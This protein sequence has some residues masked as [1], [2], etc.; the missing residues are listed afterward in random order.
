[1][2]KGIGHGLTEQEQMLSPLLAE[3]KPNCLASPGSEQGSGSS[4]CPQPWL[5]HFT[6]LWPL[7]PSLLLALLAGVILEA[8]A[9]GWGGPGF[10]LFCLPILQSLLIWALASSSDSQES[11]HESPTPSIT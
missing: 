8:A 2:W 5:Q 10:A 4:L 11:F 7:S 3:K 9:R 1:M 6:G